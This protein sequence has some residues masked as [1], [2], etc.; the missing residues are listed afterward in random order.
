MI[1]DILA[2][3]A[4]RLTTRPVTVS[5]GVTLSLYDFQPKNPASPLPVLVFVPGWVS[6]MSGWTEVLKVLT[7]KAR[8]LYLE[9]RE[10]R[11]ARLPEG[12][13]PEFTLARM[14]ADLAEVIGQELPE[15]TPFVLAG[16]SLGATVILEYLNGQNARLPRNTVLI[17]PIT[18]VD[19]PMWAQWII[20]W[21]PPSAYALIRYVAIFYLTRFRV[22]KRKEP[23]QAAKYTGTLMAAEPVRLK[24]NA[25]ALSGYS[26]WN[27]PTGVDARIL[28]VGART[29]K[30]HGLDDLRRMAEA[31]PQA[32]LSIM[33]SNRATH[34]AAVA[35][36]LLDELTL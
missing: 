33:E 3:G 18:E 23:E 16:S 32:R 1:E 9:T 25:R 5:D 15:D 6:L 35:Y 28:L 36:L 31:L 30:L 19:F 26:V 7:P 13:L 11:S 24:A 17:S 27:R 12:P 4:V 2:G 29:D 22:D 21:V 14:S 10:K 20:R 34:S 8:V